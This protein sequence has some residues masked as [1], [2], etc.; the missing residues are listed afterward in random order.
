VR[1]LITARNHGAWER[2]WRRIEP[3]WSGRGRRV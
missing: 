1:A 2:E 3:Q